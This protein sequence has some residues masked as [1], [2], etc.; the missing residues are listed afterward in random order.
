MFRF[1]FSFFI[2][3]WEAGRV[4]RVIHAAGH[5]LL[6][7]RG[8]A[9]C[10]WDDLLVVIDFDDLIGIVFVLIRGFVSQDNLLI[11]V[12]FKDFF[13]F[14]FLGFL[15]AG[16][17]CC[18][19]PAVALAVFARADKT[20]CVGVR[21]LFLGQ[22]LLQLLQALAGLIDFVQQ[23]LEPVPAPLFGDL[24]ELAPECGKLGGEFG[25]GAG[26]DTHTT[27]Q[28]FFFAA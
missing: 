14:P 7:V 19:P 1:P 25:V 8:Q 4:V 3:F 16:C 12:D 18:I 17:L 27:D 15:G 23:V 26:A 11:V 24:A 2:C 13:F 21:L 5:G 28:F 10:Y 22:T 6:F 9:V 20:G